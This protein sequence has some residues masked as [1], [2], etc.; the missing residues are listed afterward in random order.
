MHGQPN[1]SY[2]ASGNQL[3]VQPPEVMQSGA[4]FYVGCYTINKDGLPSPHSRFSDYF[5]KKAEATQC[6]DK[7]LA[8]C[9]L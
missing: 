5:P 2:S 6:L 9:S 4:G 8:S 7:A 1:D 3:G